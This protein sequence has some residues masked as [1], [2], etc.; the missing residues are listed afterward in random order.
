MFGVSALKLLK[1]GFDS[2]GAE[3]ATL[4]LGKLVAFLVSILSV[5]FLMNSIQNHDFKIFGWYRIVLGI[6]VFLY[7]IRV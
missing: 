3:L 6:I 5:K 2:T 1:F 7:F 4:G